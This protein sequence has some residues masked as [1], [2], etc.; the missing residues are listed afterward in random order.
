MYEAYFLIHGPF[1]PDILNRDK[2]KIFVNE[3]KGIPFLKEI[4][5]GQKGG[6]MEGLPPVQG[7]F[8]MIKRLGREK[9][10]GDSLN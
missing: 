10:K 6:E 2:G 4:Q 7:S 3:I 8:K 5:N 9:G 1:L